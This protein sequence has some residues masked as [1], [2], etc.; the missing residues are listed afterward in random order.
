MSIFMRCLN[1]INKVNDTIPY[2]YQ[3]KE[4]DR[5]VD[6]NFYRHQLI[7][8]KEKKPLIGEDKDLEPDDPFTKRLKSLNDSNKVGYYLNRRN[9]V[10]LW[11]QIF[12]KLFNRCR[13]EAN[14]CENILNS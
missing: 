5:I 3:L 4:G 13:N 1:I 10:K 12:G 14:S 2:T 8:Y 9:L 6:G 11:H 7:P